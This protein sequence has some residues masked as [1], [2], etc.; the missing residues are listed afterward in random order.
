MA[1]PSRQASG[2]RNRLICVEDPSATAS[3]RS[4]E[5]RR[6]AMMAVEASAMFPMIGRAMQLT[7]SGVMLSASLTGNTFKTSA[8]DSTA[9]MTVTMPSSP[10]MVQKLMLGCS[11]GSSAPALLSGASSAATLS[12]SSGAPSSCSLGG[13]SGESV[14]TRKAAYMRSST[15]AVERESASVSRSEPPGADAAIVGST[16]AMTDTSST[17]IS[18]D[19]TRRSKSCGARVAM[20]PAM[21]ESPTTSNMFERTPPRR[22]ACSTPTSPWRTAWVWH[23]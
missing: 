4:M 19:V 11:G 23:P 3:D 16:T 1:Q 2:S 12:A 14:K 10:R 6:A 18:A 13:R 21:K 7:R 5:P 20:P 22:A 8:L 15:T 9:I 17:P